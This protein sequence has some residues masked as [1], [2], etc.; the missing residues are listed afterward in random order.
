LAEVP[1]EDAGGLQQGRMYDFR[2][3]VS[4]EGKTARTY[5]DDRLIDTREG[6]FAY[7]RVG[8][9]CSQGEKNTRTYERSFYDNFK[10]TGADGTVLYEDD[11]D[12]PDFIT[13]SQ[14]DAID[15]R[16]R[17]GAYSDQYAWAVAPASYDPDLHYV[18]EADM[19]LIRDNAAII[20]S[21]TGSGTYHMWAIN[22]ADH[23][24]PC[25]RRHVYAGGGPDWSDTE[26]KGMPKEYFLNRERH[27]KI[28]VDRNVIYTYI[29]G[30]KVDT[31]KDTSGTL[32]LGLIGFR[33][34]NGANENEQAYWD[35]IK[36]TVYN[37]D[38][39]SQVRM[40]EDFEGDMNEFDDAELV[41]VDGNHKL[42]MISRN[43]ETRILENRANGAPMLRKEFVLDGD[44]KSAKLYTTALGN[45]TMFING[46]RV[47]HI[48]DDG[49]TVYDEFMP[50]WTDYR[51]KVFYN[52]H[53][54]TTL[55]KN[56]AN[57]VGAQLSNGWW[58]GDIAH[59]VYGSPDLA[60]MGKLVVELAS[61]E[62]VVV[63]TDGSW[64]TSSEGAL[65]KGD[66]YHGETF[67]ARSADRWASAGYNASGWNAAVADNQF[68][69]IVAAYEGPAVRIRRELERKPQ[70][71]T[72]YEGVKAT[73]TRYGEINVVET[74]SQC[75]GVSLKKGQTMIVD[76]GQNFVGWVKLNVKGDG[77][78]VLKMRF[79]EM[80]NDKG[81]DGRGDDGPGGSLYT[82]NL[83]NAKC[84]LN[85][86]LAGDAGGESYSPTTSFYGFRYCEL[87]AT[88]DVVVNSIVGEVVGSEL[89]EGSSLTVDNDAVNQLYSNVLWGQRSN[90]LS[91]PTDCPQRDERLGWTADTQIF[92][93]AASYNSNTLAFYHKWMGDMRDSQREDG[94]Y[95]DVAPYCWVGYG[96][97]AW[98]DAG[99]ILPWNVYSIYGDRTIIEENYE[100]MTR[101]MDYV[102]T[103]SGDGYKYNGAG[104]NYGDWVS[105]VHT[106]SR[107]VSVA[108]YA[109]M[110]DLMS[111]MSAVLSEEEGDSYDRKA[112]EYA[113]LFEEIK[114]EF[115]G[116]YLLSSGVPKINTQTAMLLALRF[117]LLPDEK[118]VDA[119][120]KRLR[121]LISGNGNKLSTG[122]VGTG[123]I[124]QT[125]SEFDM[126]DLAYTLLLQRECPSWLYSVDQG[127]TTIWERWDSY[128]K[129][130]GF[131][132]DITMNSFNHYAYGAVAEWMYRY[133]AGIAPDA[134]NAGFSH[135][136]IE[137]RPDNR[138]SLSGQQR[139]TKVDATYNSN[140]GKIRSAWVRK[141]NGTLDCDVTV[142]ANTTA[143]LYFPLASDDDPVMEGEKAAED[144]EGVEVLRVE[145][146]KAVIGL[147]S[148]SYSFRIG[149]LSGLEDSRVRVVN[150]DIKVFPN[151]T[152]GPVTIESTADIARVMV[153]DIAGCCV[154]NAAATRTV[155]LDAFP[156]GMYILTAA[157][158]DGSTAVAKVI[159][160]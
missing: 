20:F 158:V 125:L 149:S 4:D 86:V 124:N 23:S 146:G 122:F 80:L 44:V 75:A 77:G 21:R 30:Q 148:G 56:G 141:E 32:A 35:N 70:V 97:A 27:L 53:D 76:F 93:P 12:D 2:I 135:F 157:T 114:A 58:G 133:M 8:M 142:P 69:G 130:R 90:F 159:K 71:V 144:A 41:E 64:A 5:L 111:R 136:N 67:D 105:F 9:R 13:L 147:G 100:S 89:E 61:G 66:I 128:T 94:A 42:N 121:T 112:A 22:T 52:T 109:Y 120:R 59:G 117:N 36:V 37:P 54:V 123:I 3:E 81:D 48:Q 28:E 152:D 74:G 101:Y 46:T 39:T 16:L 25:L 134:E 60:F 72:I 102:A 19:T 156:C 151:P 38:G 83:R 127:A 131:H 73:G 99:V 62:T 14:G 78:T 47:G 145:N 51:K 40:N 50:G 96:Q 55:L 88:R 98:G 11:F 153:H 140:A 155:N 108:Y 129:E 92:S 45:Y 104:T 10:V 49:T 6:E 160:R 65:K 137:P 103:L 68:R 82:I 143:T 29:D 126:D 107:Y 139:I 84:L 119:T 150:N 85:Y 95:P 1:L 154:V 79:A 138:T 18:I 113:Q 118:A 17:V 43:G 34:N 132:S 57:A 33:S 87:T 106:D 31:F 24:N 15:G 63:V 7:G 115:G 116:R 26:L 91:V 110:A